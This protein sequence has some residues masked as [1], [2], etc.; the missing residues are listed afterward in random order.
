MAC[1][2]CTTSGIPNPSFAAVRAAKCAACG[3][4]DGDT[5]LPIEA[6]HPGKS[7][8]SRGTK[9]PELRCP[10]P[11]P[12]WVEEPR[13]CPKCGRQRQI[14]KRSVGCCFICENLMKVAKRNEDNKPRPRAKPSPIGLIRQRSVPARMDWFVTVTTAPRQNCTLAQCVRSLRRAGWEPTVFA[15]PDSTKTDCQTINNETRLGCWHNWLSSARWALANTDAN[16]IMTVQDDSL[17]H[18]DSKTFAESILWPDKNVGYL[19]LYTPKHYSAEVG[20]ASGVFQIRTGSMWGACALVF[21]REVLAKVVAHPVALSWL[22]V[23]P[24]SKNPAVM[25]SRKRNPHLIANSDTAIGGIINRLGLSMYYVSPSPVS[26]IATHST[27]AHGGN[28]GK[29]N[30]LNCADHHRPLAEQVGI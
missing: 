2:G 23:A 24:R 13:N 10:K 28:K 15:E 11:V 26:H 30:C 22:G 5:C 3:D 25:E 7:S 18:P 21:S 8:I 17:F 4:S 1:G 6:L 20:H 9:R 16:L 19:S 12:E 27:I 14:F 29:R